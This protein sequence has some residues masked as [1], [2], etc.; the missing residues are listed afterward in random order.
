LSR[1]GL[2]DAFE[3]MRQQEE[4]LVVG[5][6]GYP[7]VGKSST[8][9]RLMGVKKVPVSATPGRT[10]HLQTLTL[11]PTIT[12]C[13]CPG[14]VM[15]SLVMSRAQML[16]AGILPVNHMPAGASDA[17]ELVLQSVPVGVIQV[18][19][20]TNVRFHLCSKH[21]VYNCPLTPK[22]M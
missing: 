4:R 17:V 2:I 20:P 13:D 1:A 22:V 19:L 5:M 7:N 9:N 14:L 15:P 6:V 16:L 21:M 10:R 11:T 18:R 12:L 8:I 3:A